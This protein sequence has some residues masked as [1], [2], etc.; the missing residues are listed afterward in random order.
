MVSVEMRHETA[1]PAQVPV[2]PG[3]FKPVAERFAAEVRRLA[4]D[5][6]YD[7]LEVDRSHCATLT[8]CYE[9]VAGKSLGFRPST[10]RKSAEASEQ[11]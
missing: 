6:G 7:D 1:E 5:R 4:T 8:I 3:V 9:R 2:T 11:N 10:G